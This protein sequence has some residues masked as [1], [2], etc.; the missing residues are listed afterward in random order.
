VSRPALGRVSDAVSYG[1]Y[2]AGWRVVRLLPEA[3][4]YR[5]FDLVADV[6]WRRRGKGVRRLEA[7]LARA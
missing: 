6:A 1:L 4:A 3:V 5:L 2:S 7:N